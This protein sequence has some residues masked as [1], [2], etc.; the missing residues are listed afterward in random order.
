MDSVCRTLV[1]LFTTDLQMN[2]KSSATPSVNFDPGSG[3]KI[4]CKN[5]SNEKSKLQTNINN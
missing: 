3:E 5:K 1:K 4:L 2:F